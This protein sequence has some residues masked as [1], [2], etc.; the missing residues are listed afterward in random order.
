[1]IA[2]KLGRRM[3]ARGTSGQ[4]EP[5]RGPAGA[6]LAARSPLWPRTVDVVGRATSMRAEVG[7]HRRIIN[8]E[9][10]VEIVNLNIASLLALVDFPAHQKGFQSG[11]SEISRDRPRSIMDFDRHRAHF[12]RLLRP[13][14]C[15]FKLDYNQQLGIFPVWAAL[16]FRPAKLPLI[17]CH[18]VAAN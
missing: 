11:S 18:S 6:Y 7:P 8:H 9:R 4:R 3:R 12:A 2:V 1:M 16:R 5:G 17:G 10:K 13:P 14:T 15:G